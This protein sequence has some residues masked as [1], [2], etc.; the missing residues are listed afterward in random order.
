MRSTLGVIMQP[1]G[2]PSDELYNDLH[3]ERDIINYE[4]LINKPQIESHTLIGD[5]TFDELDMSRIDFD[6]LDNITS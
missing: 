1:V 6:E 2:Y 3:K 5:K 4:D